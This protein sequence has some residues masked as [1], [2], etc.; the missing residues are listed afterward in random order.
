[1][2]VAVAGGSRVS[3]TLISMPASDLATLRDRASL[4]VSSMRDRWPETLV[5][6]GVDVGP[7]LE[8]QLY[9]WLR[10]GLPA[11]RGI[12]FGLRRS[13]HAWLPVLAA[14]RAAASHSPPADAGSILAVI[15]QPVH[16]RLLE[17]VMAELAREGGPRVRTIRVGRAARGDGPGQTLDAYLDRRAV[18]PLLRTP[19]PASEGLR[20]VWERVMGPAA[21]QFV[22]A[23]RAELRLLRIAAVGLQR[24]I[25]RVDPAAV[26]TYDEVG[27]WGRLIAS[28]AR[29]AGVPSVDLPHAEAVDEVAMRGM[30]FDVVAVLGPTAADRV[31]AAGVPAER[32]VVVGSPGLDALVARAQEGGGADR[33]RR[34]VFASQYIGG[35]MTKDVKARTVRDAIDASGPAAPAE[36]VLVRHP[37]EDDGVLATAAGG[38]APAGISVRVSRQRLQD[39]LPGA[40]LL[41]TG[42]SQSVID[43][44][45]ASVP[46]I[47]INRTDGPDPVSFAA[48]GMALGAHSV[49]TARDHVAA[50]LDP[51]MHGAQVRRARSKLSARVGPLDGRAA[52]RIADLL[53]RITAGSGGPARMARG[54]GNASTAPGPTEGESV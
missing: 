6:A 35:V 26:V 13:M 53:R 8:Q 47:T 41:I 16:A 30:A 46:A 31:A 7:A 23:T 21:A 12:R 22:S 43:A 15:R 42:S 32:I 54:A 36:I 10:D 29:V 27:R 5:I 1:M 20:V 49:A 52:A 9:F 50:L 45:A 3:A 37:V 19:L 25:E 48:D 44:T 17:P 33:G 38:A 51:A 18:G 14:A 24:A 40:W 28:A 11:V 4:M 2:S 34:I 39:E